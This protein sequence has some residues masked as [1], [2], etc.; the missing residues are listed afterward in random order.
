MTASVPAPKTLSIQTGDIVTYQGKAYPISNVSS[1][2][3]G[4]GFVEYTLTLTGGPTIIVDYCCCVVS[5]KAPL[6][7]GGSQINPNYWVA[8]Q[9]PTENLQ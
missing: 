6:A 5:S 3:N 4:Q 8:T 7:V 2:D 1:A 9:Q